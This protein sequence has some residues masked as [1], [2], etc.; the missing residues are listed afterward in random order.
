MMNA[1]KHLERRSGGSQLF[2]VQRGADGKIRAGVWDRGMTPGTKL[3]DGVETEFSVRTF[4]QI[5]DNWKRRGE[6]LALCYNHQSAYVKENGRPAPAL[7]FYGAI[8][9]IDRGKL[10][11]F[12][13]L[14][15]SG[16][17]PPEVA[18]LT[19]QVA[20]LATD[21]NP[22]PSPDGCWFYRCEVTELGQELLPNFSYLSPMFLPNGQ[23]EAGEDI[24]Y[25]V[26]DLAATNTAFQAGCVI[27]FD[28]T[29]MVAIR[30]DDPPHVVLR[31]MAAKFRRLAKFEQEAKAREQAVAQLSQ[32]VGL[33]VRATLD[34]YREHP[35]LL[36]TK[37][38]TE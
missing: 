2:D 16:A 9:V 1:A 33:Y 24:G 37:E 18:S 30:R 31:R 34:L 13:R 23:N 7:A 17:R 19:A 35:E 14:A 38:E 25:T 5:T 20:Q 36:R 12:E 15:V 28:G 29:G 11:R 4:N 22:N 10:V 6:K 26:L 21:D 3:K 8:A 27:T 32:V